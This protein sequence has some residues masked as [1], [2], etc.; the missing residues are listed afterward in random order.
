MCCF[1]NLLFCRQKDLLVST[2]WAQVWKLANIV[3]VLPWIH[4][5]AHPLLRSFLFSDAFR[6]DKLSLKTR[7]ALG[8]RR[9]F[10]GVCTPPNIT[11][12]TG[13]NKKWAFWKQ[14]KSKL[15]KLSIFEVG[16]WKLKMPAKYLDTGWDAHKKTTAPQQN[17]GRGESVER[18]SHPHLRPPTILTTWTFAFTKPI[19]FG[20]KK[21]AVSNPSLEGSNMNEAKKNTKASGHDGIFGFHHQRPS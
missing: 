4:Q 11:S 6:C 10:G 1:F 19:F 12:S 16:I 7:A 3:H 8:M 9:F 2:L 17:A 21:R 20:L 14:N 13:L 15:S 18:S 5:T